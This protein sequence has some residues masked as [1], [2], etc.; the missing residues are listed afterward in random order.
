MYCC[1]IHCVLGNLHSGACLTCLWIKSCLLT[2][3]RRKKLSQRLSKKYLWL[4][5]ATRERREARRN[6]QFP[7]GVFFANEQA[8]AKLHLQFYQFQ[9]HSRQSPSG[10]VLACLAR[11]RRMARE[12]AITDHCDGAGS[13][14]QSDAGPVVQSQ[15]PIHTTSR[16]LL[17]LLLTRLLT[18]LWI[19][20]QSELS[21]SLHWDVGHWL[22]PIHSGKMAEIRG[23][24]YNKET[25]L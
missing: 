10:Y 3:R 23:I 11:A 8:H 22:P 25:I 9:T 6:P 5:A 17:I 1:S 4:S 19:K 18:V 14:W 12:A 7:A 15:R 24:M 20:Q 21:S 2:H 16:L 13:Q